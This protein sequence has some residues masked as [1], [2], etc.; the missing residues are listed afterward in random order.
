MSITQIDDSEAG[1][2]HGHQAIAIGPGNTQTGSLANDWNRDP[3][4]LWPPPLYQAYCRLHFLKE[5]SL[6]HLWE[7]ERYKLK[8]EA[9]LPKAK[10]TRKWP[11]SPTR[12]QPSRRAREKI[13]KYQSEIPTS[14]TGSPRRNPNVANVDEPSNPLDARREQLRLHLP[15][16]IYKTQLEERVNQVV[17]GLLETKQESADGAEWNCASGVGLYLECRYCRFNP[18]VV[19]CEGSKPRGLRPPAPMHHIWPENISKE[20]ISEFGGV[21]FAVDLSNGR[22]SII[23]LG[24]DP[25]DDSV[26]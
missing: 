19:D 7:N 4:W 3:S 24:M 22:E 25:F 9:N 11:A 20:R 14:R 15:W 10:K 21:K 12:V 26:E 23:L 18:L 13:S 5:S 8:V 6:Y 16:P 17:S 2:A 1:D